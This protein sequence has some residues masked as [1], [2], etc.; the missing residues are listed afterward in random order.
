MRRTFT[1]ENLLN[2]YYAFGDSALRFCV[3]HWANNSQH[4][5]IFRC[6]KKIVR[7]IFNKKR[8]YSCVELFRENKILTYYAIYALELI[9]Y[10]HDNKHEITELDVALHQHNT[11]Y[12]TNKPPDHILIPRSRT[13]FYEKSSLISGIR[14]YNTIPNNIKSLNRNMFKSHI[15]N[16]LIDMTPY[17]FDIKFNT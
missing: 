11:R 13:K 9:L 2:F 16:N 4:E 1:K 6:Q 14:M 7:A 3:I 15:K 17:N 12:Q 10:I 5:R 8:T